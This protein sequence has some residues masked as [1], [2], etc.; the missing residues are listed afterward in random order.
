MRLPFL[1]RED[2]YSAQPSNSLIKELEL[3]GGQSVRRRVLDNHMIRF[4]VSYSLKRHQYEFLIEFYEQWLR[5]REPS[6]RLKYFD[7]LLVYQPTNPEYPL[8]NFKCIFTEEPVVVSEPNGLDIIV[9][10]VLEGYFDN[11]WPMSAL[12][13]VAGEAGLQMN[14]VQ[15]F[16]GLFWTLPPDNFSQGQASFVS[17]QLNQQ[18]FH[19]YDFLDNYRQDGA[20]F[21]SGV[22]TQWVFHD[23]ES[24][25]EY[26]QNG[27]IFES[28]TIRD[29]LIVYHNW[30][31]E[32][33]KFGGAEFSQGNLS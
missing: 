25:E 17:G 13:P 26:M 5:D 18:V 29:Q 8:H 28:G 9:S 31:P 4:Q 14:Q 16:D 7:T 6:G 12:Y 33:I 20:R 32:D 23:L 1:P 19:F 10:T 2:G 21:E 30:P 27:A 11:W 22:L 3:H 24:A 15:F